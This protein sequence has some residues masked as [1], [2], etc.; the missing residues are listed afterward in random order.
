MPPTN[1]NKSVNLI[2]AISTLDIA[3]IWKTHYHLSPINNE[4]MAMNVSRMI[5][6]FAG[7]FIMLSLVMAHVLDQIDITLVSWLWFVAFVGFNLFQS[8]FTGFCP[9]GKILKAAGVK[10]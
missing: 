7:L 4:D 3:N 1:K 2:L 10:E 6:M 9:L 8:S 5:N